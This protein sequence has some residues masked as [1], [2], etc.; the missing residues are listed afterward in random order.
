M[1]MKISNNQSDYQN[2]QV[3]PVV[4]AEENGIIDQGIR[5]SL[6]ANSMKGLMALAK[7][8]VRESDDI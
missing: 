6:S 1:E 7:E 5:S 3:N 4:G 2:L 8:I